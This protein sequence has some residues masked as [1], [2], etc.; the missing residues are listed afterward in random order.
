[1]PRNRADHH[2]LAVPG[3]LAGIRLVA[4]DLDSTL[5]RGQ[6]CMEAIADALGFADTPASSSHPTARTP[7]QPRNR[8]RHSDSCG[9]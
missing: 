5:T 1:M 8:K 7:R 6:T 2:H 3:T 9:I 4:F